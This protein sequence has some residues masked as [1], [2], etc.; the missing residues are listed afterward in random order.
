MTGRNEVYRCLPREHSEVLHAGPGELVCCGQPMKLQ[1]ANTGRQLRKACTGSETVSGG[2]RLG[3]SAAHPMI[4]EHY[5]EWI[6]L[7]SAEGNCRRF[8]NPGE[9][10]EVEFKSAETASARSIVTCTAF[11]PANR[12]GTCRLARLFYR[13]NVS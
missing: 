1:V 3:G 5:I 4:P 7:V 2:F 6:D 10:P 13:M 11:G 12:K 9:I 8:L